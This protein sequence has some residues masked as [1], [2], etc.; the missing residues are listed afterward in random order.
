MPLIEEVVEEKPS[1]EMTQLDLILSECNAIKE[2]GNTQFK[3]KELDEAEK[4][5]QSALYKILTFMKEEQ[6]KRKSNDESKL[7]ENLENLNLNNSE[8]VEPSSQEQSPSDATLLQ[9]QDD[10]EILAPDLHL[11]GDQVKSLLVTLYSNLALTYFQMQHYQ[12]CIDCS[13][14]V[15]THLEKDHYKSLYKRSQSYE[16]LQKFQ[17]SYA[18]MKQLTEIIASKRQMGVSSDIPDQLAKKFFLDAE[19]LRIK[20]EEEQKKQVEEMWGQLKDVGN[21]L[22]GA[23]GLNLNNFKFDKDP[24]SG[25]YSISMNK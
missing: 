7:S 21:Q 8:K 18:D 25:G 17:L 2:K 24:N 5:Y 14:K 16:E 13:T 12:K 20:S 15:L 19:R 3:A 23:F 22:L 11:F 6:I 1:S 10:I 4:I 9:E